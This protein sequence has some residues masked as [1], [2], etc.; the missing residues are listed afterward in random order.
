MSTLVSVVALQPTMTAAELRTW[1]GQDEALSFRTE[2]WTYAG[3]ADRFG[4]AAAEGLGAAMQAAG[5][6]TAVIAYA[7]RGFDLSLDK[8]RANLSAIAAAVPDLAAV[9]AALMAI[10]RPTKVRWEY[11]GLGA[12]PTVEQ[13]T[14]AKAALQVEQWAAALINETIL[15]AVA[16]GKTVAQIKALVA[17]A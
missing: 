12:L 7:A 11:F 13:L 9:C 17:G 10:G 2:L 14:A 1:L 4:E 15:P 5:L 16:E 3:V 6:H 8:T